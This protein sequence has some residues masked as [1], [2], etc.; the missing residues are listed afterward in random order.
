[1]V[2]LTVVGRATLAELEEYVQAVT[3]AGATAYA[4]I[5]DGTA[6]EGGLDRAEMLALAARFREF[7]DQPLGP[8]AIVMSPAARERLLPML[9]VLAAG[10]RPLQFFDSVAS[11][12][13]WLKRLAKR[14]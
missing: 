4:K 7:H 10:D 6:S 1:M 11:A 5:Y 12:R 13:R 9:G 8:L 3:G 2:I 14:S